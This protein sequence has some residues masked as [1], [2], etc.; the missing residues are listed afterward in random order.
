LA[1]AQAKPFAGNCIHTAGGITDQRD[2]ST[3]D[4]AKTVH[5]RSRASFP[6]R[7]LSTRKPLLQL[8]PIPQ[9]IV[10]I[11]VACVISC[12]YDA[13]FLAG[14]SSNVSLAT[15]APVDLHEFS[16]GSDEVMAPGCV[17]QAATVACI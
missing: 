9:G 8:G 1:E 15:F 16:P 3:N 4:V 14:N 5:E 7:Q 17:P 2:I 10:K 6:A 13:D 12:Q 11:G